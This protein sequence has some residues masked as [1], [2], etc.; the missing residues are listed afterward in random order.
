VNFLPKK[1]EEVE[2]MKEV[3]IM[4]RETTETVTLPLT[5]T[6]LLVVTAVRYETINQKEKLLA[7]YRNTHLRPIIEN[8]IDLHGIEDANGSKIWN[9][10]CVTMIRQRS[11]KIAFNEVVAEDI[12]KKKGLWESCS[13]KQIIETEEI[14]QEKVIAAYE[15]GLIS[16]KDYAKMFSEKESY[17]L[18]IKPEEDSYPDYAKLKETRIALE[19]GKI[20]KM[21]EIE[22]ETL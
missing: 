1:Q 10:E 9:E 14:D 8:A 6:Q 17:S 13:T 16:P 2:E 20:T 7:A 3:A 11:A 22:V 5:K 4:E 19:K 12:L 21:E 15:G 18:I